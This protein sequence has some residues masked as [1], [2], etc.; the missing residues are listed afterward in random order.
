MKLQQRVTARAD[1]W[2]R[3]LEGTHGISHALNAFAKSQDLSIDWV[4][5]ANMV[6]EL[7]SI[8]ANALSTGV[9]A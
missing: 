4:L 2:L 5:F 7:A 1:G 6:N 8:L 9:L 3:V